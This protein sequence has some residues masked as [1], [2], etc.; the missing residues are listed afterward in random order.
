MGKY[1]DAGLFLTVVGSLIL[2][3]LVV[4]PTVAGFFTPEQNAG[5]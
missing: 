1:F 2:Y 5:A 3:D 4:G